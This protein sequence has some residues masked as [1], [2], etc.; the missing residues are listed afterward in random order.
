[1]LAGAGCI[2][3]EPYKKLLVDRAAVTH[4]EK[5]VNIDKMARRI[6]EAVSKSDMD[7]V[8]RMTL[9]E[10]IAG[11]KPGTFTS[12]GGMVLAT[13]QFPEADSEWFD[14][15]TSFISKIETYLR[16]QEIDN[17]TVNVV[18]NELFLNRKASRESILYQLGKTQSL[19]RSM[20]SVTSAKTLV[21]SAAYRRAI[22]L[23]RRKVLRQ[24]IVNSLPE[25][26]DGEILEFKGDSVPLNIFN[27]LSESD[28]G[29]LFY[30]V[31]REYLE[32]VAVDPLTRGKGKG[33]VM[34]VF[35][36]MVANPY[37]NTSALARKLGKDDKVVHRARAILESLYPS[38]L[39]KTMRDPRTRK[40]V[41]R[42]EVQEEFNARV[43]RR[44]SPLARNLITI[45]RT[46]GVI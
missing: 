20:P 24:R 3:H 6:V 37:D 39:E 27:M 7:M 32:D 18:I 40:I 43:A 26:K 38:V 10:G 23:T 36:L 21:A 31:F 42:I 44:P 12:M 14:R 30:Q 35:D 34:A 1:M 2:P 11:V 19:D 46:A 29:P 9:L 5:I 16:N 33:N 4:S 22:D 28:D 15:G 8:I 45:L 17:D 13:R 25:G 41:K